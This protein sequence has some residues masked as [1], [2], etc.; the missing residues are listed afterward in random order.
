MSRKHRRRHAPKIV[1]RSAPGAPTGIVVPD[2]SQPKPQI[3]VIV[4][5]PGSIVGPFTQ[6]VT[7]Y[8]DE[9]RTVNIDGAYGKIIG[10]VVLYEGLRWQQTG[11]QHMHAFLQGCK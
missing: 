6:A 3:H 7:G 8:A 9:V 10:R 2:P 4:Y 11:I 1:R 5:G